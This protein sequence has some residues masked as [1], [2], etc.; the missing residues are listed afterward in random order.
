MFRFS[1]RAW[2]WPLLSRGQAPQLACPFLG[3]W[4]PQPDAH[5][6]SRAEPLTG[7]VFGCE[8]HPEICLP[9]ALPQDSTPA[10][11]PALVLA[12]GTPDLCWQGGGGALGAGTASR[13][14]EGSSARS[15]GHR[16]MA[17]I[18][19]LRAKRSRLCRGFGPFWASTLSGRRRFPNASFPN[20]SDLGV[21]RIC[22]MGMS[23][24]RPCLQRER[25]REGAGGHSG[26]KDETHK[27]FP[28]LG[29]GFCWVCWF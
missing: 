16:W 20:I 1:R 21:N 7:L 28:D 13:T 9:E 14:L 18:V 19:T 15:P 5:R 8:L 3:T 24:K 12:S 4:G 29:L 22:K 27:L 17:L 25:K 11:H 23:P 2:L 10:P 26:G 6:P